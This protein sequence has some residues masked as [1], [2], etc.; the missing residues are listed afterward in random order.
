MLDNM[1][2]DV[3]LKSYQDIIVANMDPE[4]IKKIMNYQADV[5]KIPAN[6]TL[7]PGEAKGTAVL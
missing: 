4:A 1:Y 6:S 7:N 3:P 2:Y 5:L